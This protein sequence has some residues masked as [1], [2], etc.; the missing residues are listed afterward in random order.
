MFSL[1]ETRRIQL[2]RLAFIVLCALPTIGVIAWCVVVNG[3]VYRHLHQR[4]I[5]AR[6]QCVARLTRASSPR[7]DL[8]LYEGLDLTDRETGQLLARFG[9]VEVQTAAD[10]VTVRLPLPG[11]INGRRLVDVGRLALAQ[12]QASF[13]AKPLQ[14]E[15]GHLTLSLPSGDQTLTDLVGRVAD[16]PRQS[17]LRLTFARATA[18]DL[19][20]T[21]IE[22]SLIRNQATVLRTTS[23]EFRTEGAPLP[24]ELLSAIWPAVS[25]LGPECT[26]AGRILASDSTAGW[27][28]NLDG[29]V[30]HVD[31]DRLMGPFPH[32]LTGQA[33]I[34][35]KHV[36]VRDGRVE[37][38]AGTII[39][40]PGTISRSLVQSALTGLRLEGSPR[41]FFGL[42]NRIGY[43]Q[44]SMAFDLGADGLTLHG[45]VAEPPGTILLAD[46]QVLLKEPTVERQP[47]LNLVRTLV[48]QVALQVPATRET[49]RLTR[50]LPIP[51][52]AAPPGQ[53]TALP[54]A[55]SLR[56]TPPKR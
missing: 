33:S 47:V 29:Q 8:V 32:K 55:R 20:P 39:G 52:V 27:S 12:T 17:R 42:D 50:W 43:S 35:L 14:I 16:E 21:R 31:L 6:F 51:P 46:D 5:S 23:V 56:V 22:T 25:V 4:A 9:A 44:L 18:G 13:G 40:G 28:L 36:A 26:F 3:P 48:P 49:D 54:E 38:A 11:M 19:T 37:Q 15:A 30:D 7:P 10:M 41:V 1:H 53:E 45:R 24:C 34:A 2:C